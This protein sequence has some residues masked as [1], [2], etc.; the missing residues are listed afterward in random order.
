MNVAEA[1]A[2]V[3]HIHKDDVRKDPEV[4]IPMP[5]IVHVISVFRR[6]NEW[7]IW[8]VPA[9]LGSLYHDVREEKGYTSS[10]V[11]ADIGDE[12]A[13]YV[14]DLTYLPGPTNPLT[15]DEYIASF[16]DKP[17]YA[18]LIKIADRIDN[19]YDFAKFDRIYARE[20]ALKAELL[21]KA[22]FDRKAEIVATVGG[23]VYFN[24]EF[25]I[26]QMMKDINVVFASE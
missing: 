25:A 21:F 19:V 17:V 7:G 13:N 1:I 11:A 22:F 8:H 6:L 10:A 9:L 23:D 18:L 15:K 16:K 4:G 26:W 14:D 5:Y 20:Y 2:R 24:I 3:A 12:A